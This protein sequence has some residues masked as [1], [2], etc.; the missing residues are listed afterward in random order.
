MLSALLI[1]ATMVTPV[2]AQERPPG[3]ERRGPADRRDDDGPGWSRGPADG[4][5]QPRPDDALPDAF[6][7]DRYRVDGPRP[8]GPRPDGPRFDDRRPDDRRPDDRRPDRDD[9]RPAPPR[10]RNGPGRFDDRLDRRDWTDQVGRRPDPRRDG[11]RGDRGDRRFPD[12][13]GDQ[14]WTGGNWNRNWRSDGRYDWRAYRDDNDR[15]FRAPRYYG[16]RG[17]DYGYRRWTPGYRIAPAYYGQGYWIT[18]PD[19]YR[20]PPVDGGYR[21]IRYYDDVALIDLRS[22]LIVDILYSFFL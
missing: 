21:W 15:A 14:R 4:P 13:Y 16:P 3:E 7:A 2:A 1:G 6:R 5:R 20:L 22:G 9:P 17:L 11:P 8:D 18:R 19:R 12:N 10:D